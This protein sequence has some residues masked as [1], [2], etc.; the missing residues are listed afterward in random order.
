MDFTLHLTSNASGD[1]FKGNTLTS[2]RVLLQKYERLDVPPA[3]TLVYLTMPSK[4][5]NVKRGE[6]FLIQ[7]E[8]DAT[9]PTYV[10]VH[11]KEGFDDGDERRARSATSLRRGGKISKL[12]QLI[13]TGSDVAELLIRARGRLLPSLKKK[14][15]REYSEVNR[16]TC[17]SYYKQGEWKP[18][19]I[20][21]T[22]SINWSSRNY[23]SC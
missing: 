8:K 2:Y 12:R 14:W 11:N 16:P 20:W 9:I 13:E 21:C 4:W 22:S 23:L 5:Y 19:G 1:I 7:V 3:C 18:T 17:E 15:Q 6:L 10:E